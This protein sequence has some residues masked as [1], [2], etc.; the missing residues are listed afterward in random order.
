MTTTTR[1]DSLT[2]VTS[3]ANV[4]PILSSPSQRTI[5]GLAVPYGP[6][7][8][9]SAGA[10]TFSQ[11]SLTI[12]ESVGRV[13]LLLQHDPERVIGYATKLEDR[14][15]GL[16]AEFA[17][18]ASDEGDKALSEAA[19][20]RRDG[21]SVGVMLNEDVLGEVVDKWMSGDTTPTAAAG[22]LLEISQ[23][24]LPAF[25]DSRIDGSAAAALTGHITLSVDFGGVTPEAAASPKKEHNMTVETP[26]SAP[27]SAEVETPVPAAVAGGALVASEAPVYTFNGQGPS[28]VRDAFN[29]RFSYDI[30]AQS[31]LAK[32]NEQM[33]TNPVQIL[34]VRSAVDN[35][36]TAAVETRATAPN[37]I[38]QGYRPDL[39]IEAIDKGRPLVSRIGTTPLSDATPFRIPSE[40]DFTGVGDHTEGTAHVAEGD[41]TMGD[42]TVTPGAISGAYR[43]SRELVDASNPAIDRLAL[44]AMLRGY[45]SASEAK[46][47]AAL[48]A[49]DGTADLNINTV[50]EVRQSL[51]SFY[52]T[53]AESADF[54]AS[55]TSFVNTLLADVD[56][57]GRPHL[58]SINPQNAVGVALP[59][60]SG[61][62]I[63]GTE[64]VKSATVAVNDAFLVNAE[65]V[66]IG[67]SSVQTF[68]FDEVEGP[69]VIKLAL[70]AYFVAKVTRASGVVQIT[71][72]AA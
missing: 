48:L 11:G 55:S 68:R 22:E 25:R 5:S 33:R 45:R 65:D 46:V 52:D 14:P 60:S 70:W 29:A 61:Y 54:I 4:T 39:L 38:N 3:A 16:W 2:I 7:G 1:P 40:G 12:P 35:L 18:P 42:V 8:N 50:L 23:V 21:L 56:T 13:K 28:F 41:M 44:Q 19:D 9:S 71:S 36:A 47:V 59:G 24:S 58:A 67:E 69:G 53:N 20:G 66:F 30:E 6:V 17:V 64:L 10:I 34:L 63:D 51:N 26:V 49:A 27:A 62:F 43:L 37:M 15:D 57:T 32:F 72:A 31:R